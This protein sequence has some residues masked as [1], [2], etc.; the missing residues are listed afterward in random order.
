ML[1][2]R[3]LIALLLLTVADVGGMYSVTQFCHQSVQK[4]QVRLSN[5]IQLNVSTSDLSSQ[6]F[7]QSAID[8][9]HV[10]NILK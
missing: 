4:V 9:F 6:I 10:L 1:I 3:T 2:L 8:E 5:K 7:T